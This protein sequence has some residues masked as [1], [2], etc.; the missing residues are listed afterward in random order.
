M[1]EITS[2]YNTWIS[3]EGKIYPVKIWEHDNVAYMICQA[4]YSISDSRD[5]SHILQL[6]GWIKCSRFHIIPIQPI[7]KFKITQKQLD[8]LFDWV[9]A[10]NSF[11]FLE[12]EYTLKN[13]QKFINKI[14]RI[15]SFN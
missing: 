8:L 3:P 15:K 13:Y 4:I 2:I 10:N 12:Q 1:C 11:Y 7:S 6:L 14:E 9:S 5:F